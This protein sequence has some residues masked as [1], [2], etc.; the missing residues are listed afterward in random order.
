MEEKVTNDLMP[1]KVIIISKTLCLLISCNKISRNINIDESQWLLFQ[2][3]CVDE[4][5]GSLMN[6]FKR[7]Y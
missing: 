4:F 7:S 1:K 2:P 5:F 3:T 6:D